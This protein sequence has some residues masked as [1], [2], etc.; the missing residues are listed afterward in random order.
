ME[1]FVT[2]EQ[3]VRRQIYLDNLPFGDAL[4]LWEEKLREYGLLTPLKGEEIPV[5]SSQGRVTAE[6]VS[7]NISSPFYHC[8]AMDGVAVRFF[9]T[10][11]AS[12]TSPKILKIGEQAVEVDTGDPMPEGFNAVIMIEDVNKVSDNE[13]EIIKPATPWQHVRT[14][15]EDIVA[16][17]LILS[18]NHKIRPVDMGAMLAGGITKISVR[19]RPKIVI[20][21]TGT[22]LIEPGTKLE[23]GGI[24]EYNSSILGGMAE[25][26]GCEAVRWAIVKDDYG[27][28]KAN[29]L[30]A[31][32]AGD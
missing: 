28:L 21:P 26:W 24:I 20:I 3:K 4:K 10:F 16:T 8:A 31:L 13:I 23:R 7:A 9:D 29:I 18:E 17:E 19:R 27:L 14:I 5:W 6:A 32:D 30:K 15:G 2:K 25:E 1:T 22:E 12:E 11:G